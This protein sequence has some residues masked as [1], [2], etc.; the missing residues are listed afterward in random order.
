MRMSLLHQFALSIEMG[1][2]SELF[3]EVLGLAW[4]E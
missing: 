4:Q 2:G 1:I 3:V